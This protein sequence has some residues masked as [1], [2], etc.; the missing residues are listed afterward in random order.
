M[1]DHAGAG[2]ETDFDL[3]AYEVDNHRRIAAI[4]DVDRLET[5]MH[6]KILHHQM[7]GSSV[8]AAGIGDGF[9]PGGGGLREG[10]E[11][12]HRTDRNRRMHD[13]H[14]A[15]RGKDRNW[16]DVL[17]RV[18]GQLAVKARIHGQYRVEH[19]PQCVAVRSGS[20]DDFGSDVAARARPIF[21]HKWLLEARGHLVSDRPRCD[22][23]RPTGNKWNDELDDAIG[24]ALRRGGSGRPW[25]AANRRGGQEDPRE[26]RASY[27][28]HTCLPHC[29]LRLQPCLLST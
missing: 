6:T 15:E 22:V 10:N 9:L 8:A 4:W 29:L 27:R 1:I 21:D 3:T 13:Q 20:G 12:R 18:E 16:P 5:G 17:V 11:L 26:T 28:A 25:I 19:H 23:G 14:V 7:A 2:D 24:V